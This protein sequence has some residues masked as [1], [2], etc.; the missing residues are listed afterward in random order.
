[1]NSPPAVEIYSEQ[2]EVIQPSPA[3]P[4]PPA[5]AQIPEGQW[6]EGTVKKLAL[7]H[8]EVQILD[9][10]DRVK[11][12]KEQFCDSKMKP[13]DPAIYK[14]LSNKPVQIYS[15]QGIIYACYNPPQ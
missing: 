3:I 2:Q 13:L 9:Y 8:S 15:S 12:L 6:L 5:S 10:P 14:K 4:T 7:K 1:V 11:V